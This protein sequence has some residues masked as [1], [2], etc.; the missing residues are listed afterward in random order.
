MKF[1]AALALI[2]PV[3][4]AFTPTST[5]K[6]ELLS[7]N[8]DPATLS[9]AVKANEPVTAPETNAQRLRRGLNPLAPRN[10]RHHGRSATQGELDEPR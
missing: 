1:F 5:T 4:S 3:V 8:P 9:P 6:R 10:L 2:L 7:L